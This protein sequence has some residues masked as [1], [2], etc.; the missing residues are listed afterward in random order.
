MASTE[1][2]DAERIRGTW[3]MPSA[4]PQKGGLMGFFE[5]THPLR[6]YNSLTKKLTPF[7]PM[8]PGLVTMCA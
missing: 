3:R 8:Q 7:V 6:V 1:E 4:L 5:S 2:T